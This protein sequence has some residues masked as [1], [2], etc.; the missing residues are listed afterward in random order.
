MVQRQPEGDGRE[1]SFSRTLRGRARRQEAGG[2][3]QTEGEPQSPQ[4]LG[5]SSVRE[6]K[7]EERRKEE[8]R[9]REE[10][11]EEERRRGEVETESP[12]DGQS[13][14]QV[15]IVTIQNLLQALPLS[16][17]GA[18]MRACK[19]YR[20]NIPGKLYRQYNTGPI[21]HISS[22]VTVPS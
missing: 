13:G 7:R 21:L 4:E 11:R 18:G 12:R 6:R 17:S 16:Q 3:R 2:R 9:R 10:G 5:R 22:A 19:Q 1:V 14:T 20:V 8:K 15:R